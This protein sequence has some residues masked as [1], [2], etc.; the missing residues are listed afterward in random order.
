MRLA[1]CMWC[2]ALLMTA[3]EVKSWHQQ[4]PSVWGQLTDGWKLALFAEKNCYTSSEPVVVVVVANNESG[5]TL[6]VRANQGQWGMGKMT[7]QRY[8]HEQEI[9]LRPARNQADRL[10]RYAAFMKLFDLP[11]GRQYS[12]GRASLKEMF[13]LGSG[14]YKITATV[15][16][17]SPSISPSA[18][19]AVS[20]NTLRISI[21]DDCPSSDTLAEPRN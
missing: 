19:V 9:P 14:T 6:R 1:I 17:L 11:S 16:L 21:K 5:K 7:V 8:G 10:E 12:P 15:D 2:S 3:Q 20:S 18:V 4:V 13:D